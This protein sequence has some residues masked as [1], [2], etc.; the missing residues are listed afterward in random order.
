M[1]R[2]RRIFATAFSPTRYF[3]DCH[4]PYVARV[5]ANETGSVRVQGVIG[6]KLQAVDERFAAIEECAFSSESYHNL[7][8]VCGPEFQ[9]K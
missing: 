5:T 8:R 6:N 3:R 1:A 2:V 9:S 7:A 4:S